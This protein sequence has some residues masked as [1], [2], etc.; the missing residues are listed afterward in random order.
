MKCSLHAPLAERYY[1]ISECGRELQ[2][3]QVKGMRM[4][5]AGRPRWMYDRYDSKH[6]RLAT[7]RFYD[8]D[9]NASLDLDAWG[10]N[11][12][13]HEH[14]PHVH[15]WVNGKRARFGRKMKA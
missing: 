8:A 11:E 1:S 3:L 13:A 6:G 5:S 4:G 2:L 7:R 14:E 12:R 15:D 9:E 10:H